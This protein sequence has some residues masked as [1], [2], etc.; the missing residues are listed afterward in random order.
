MKKHI[1]LLSG[2]LFASGLFAQVKSLS[3]TAQPA[4]KVAADLKDS[5]KIKTNKIND[6]KIKNGNLNKKVT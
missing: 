4:K 1:T 6:L 5:E 3:V 2:L